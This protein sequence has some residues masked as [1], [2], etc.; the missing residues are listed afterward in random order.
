MKRLPRNS[1]VIRDNRLL[2]IW[3]LPDGRKLFQ[4]KRVAATCPLVPEE[5]QVY[6]SAGDKQATI[7]FIARRRQCSLDNAAI[8]FH[9]AAYGVSHPFLKGS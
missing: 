8:L 1:I 5:C 4:G 9:Q 7:R 6:A 3:Q 2:K